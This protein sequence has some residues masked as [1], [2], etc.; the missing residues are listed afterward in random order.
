MKFLLTFATVLAMALAGRVVAQDSDPFTRYYANPKPDRLLGFLDRFQQGKDW[1]AFPP[2]AG[3][4]AVIFRRHPE[5]SDRLIPA[6]PSGRTAETIAVAFKLA[7][8]ADIPAPVRS[9]LAAAGSDAKL[10]AE[11][12]NLPP[13][14]EAIAVATPTHLDI[15]WGASFASGDGRYTAMIT[16]FFARTAD[17]SEAMAQDVCGLAIAIRRQDQTAVSEVAS[18]HP[19]AAVRRELLFAATAGWGLASNADQHP[20]VR[21]ALTKWV[22]DHPGS[23]AGKCLSTIR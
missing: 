11:Y 15:L 1:N 14:L 7:G 5:W 2:A 23:R 4:F 6:Q 12:A 21:A 3:F 18:R 13:A 8:R 22:A 20:F 19:D 9:R 16:D 17:R 10:Q